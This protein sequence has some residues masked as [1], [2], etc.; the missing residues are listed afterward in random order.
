MIPQEKMAVKYVIENYKHKQEKN[1]QEQ[2]Y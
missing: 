2:I 1:L